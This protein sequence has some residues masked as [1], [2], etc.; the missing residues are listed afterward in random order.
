MKVLDILCIQRFFYCLQ[1]TSDFFRNV[2][3]TC[4]KLLNSPWLGGLVGWGLKGCGF[5]PWSGHI[6]GLLGACGRQPI[7]V[8][9]T[10]MCLPPSLPLSLSLKSIN[11]SSGKDLKEKSY[12][13]ISNLINPAFSFKN[14]GV[15]HIGK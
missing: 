11:I 15:V 12:K 7:D 13:F 1:S 3:N 5:G 2:V 8:S 6:P 14:S 4:Q 9:L 10:S